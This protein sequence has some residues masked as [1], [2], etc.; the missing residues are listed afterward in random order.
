MPLNPA[1]LKQSLTKLG[2]KGSTPASRA[3]G[4]KKFAEAYDSYAKTATALALGVPFTPTGAETAKMLPALIP[5]FAAPTG[6]P[7]VVANAFGAAVTA[8]WTGAVFGTGIAAPPTG[9][10]ALVPALQTLLLNPQ[11]PLDLAMGQIASALDAC[12]RTVL[13]TFVQPPPAPPIVSP[14]G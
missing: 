14:I 7:A 5:A 9:V 4:A 13:V 3:D 10:A 2:Q 8:Y 1:A 12:T 11:N 6:N